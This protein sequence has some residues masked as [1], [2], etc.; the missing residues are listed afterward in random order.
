MERWR[1]GGGDKIQQS[2]LEKLVERGPLKK[3]EEEEEEG[4]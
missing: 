2:L 1:R 3:K 4:A